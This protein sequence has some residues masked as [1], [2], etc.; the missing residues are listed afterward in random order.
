[1]KKKQAGEK[2]EP[3]QPIQIRSNPPHFGT[4][5]LGQPPEGLDRLGQCQWAWISC[6][7]PQNPY[8]TE[9]PLTNAEKQARF[10]DR[11]V[12]TLTGAAGE[13]AAKLI[14]MSDQKK[15]KKVHRIVATYL[16]DPQRATEA[17]KLNQALKAGE[18]TRREYERYRFLGDNEYWPPSLP[19]PKVT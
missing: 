3:A 15:L 1:L 7:G 10:R 9:M 17:R 18:I 5:H 13:I 6:N 16:K 14:D 2:I 11:N 8:V 4:E 12:V 19:R